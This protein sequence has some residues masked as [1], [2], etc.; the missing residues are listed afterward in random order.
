M[1][2]CT[3]GAF[4]HGHRV[5]FAEWFNSLRV[6]DNPLSSCCGPGDQ[7]YMRE[8][9]VSDKR[10]LA[11]EGEIDGAV[12]GMAD[13]HVE[14]PLEKVEWDRVNPTGRGVIFMGKTEWGFSP[15]VICF[16]PSGGA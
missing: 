8:Y 4:G 10:G 2:A 11:F 16:V 7:F 5:Q 9:H 6:P 12:H 3:V 15:Y 13:F 1:I 14:V